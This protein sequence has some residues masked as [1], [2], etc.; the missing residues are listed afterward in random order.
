MSCEDAT[1]ALSSNR[2]LERVRAH[3]RLDMARERIRRAKARALEFGHF[4]R[5]S[6]RGRGVWPGVSGEQALAKSRVFPQ[7]ST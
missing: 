3:C 5:V 1:R 2:S 6:G 4:G 7:A